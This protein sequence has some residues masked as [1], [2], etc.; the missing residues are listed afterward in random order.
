MKQTTQDNLA[1]FFYDCGKVGFAVLV[2]GVVA[3]KPFAVVD[4]F[5]GVFF[6]TVL[7]AVGYAFDELRRDR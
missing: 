2:I 1:R 3:R 7:L 6:T 5:S 4:F